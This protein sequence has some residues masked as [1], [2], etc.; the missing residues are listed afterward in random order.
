METKQ[1]TQKMNLSVTEKLLIVIDGNIV[2]GG[3][4]CCFDNDDPVRRR[5]IS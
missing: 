1:V 3:I 5:G 2:G 4:I